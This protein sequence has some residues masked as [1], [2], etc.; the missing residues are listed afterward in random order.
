MTGAELRELMDE[1]ATLLAQGAAE[2]RAAAAAATLAVDAAAF[3]NFD[4]ALEHE[5]RA[6]QH[7]EAAARAAASAGRMLRQARA[8]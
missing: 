6:H 5:Q 7:R 2:D 8:G 3:G 1:A 4:L